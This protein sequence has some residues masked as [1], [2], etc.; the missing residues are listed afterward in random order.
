MKGQK[1]V[2][3]HDILF[4]EA[5]MVN[6]FE[7]ETSDNDSYVRI[8]LDNEDVVED[9]DC[10]NSNSD[11]PHVVSEPPI[12]ER[13]PVRVRKRPDYHGEYVNLT[14]CNPEPVTVSEAHLI[15]RDGKKPWMSR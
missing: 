9:A 1:I 15:T 2:Y 4:N 10:E 6:C 13:R 3:G 11:D 8:E 12:V 7:K 5:E 14:D